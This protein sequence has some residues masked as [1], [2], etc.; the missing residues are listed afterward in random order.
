M[1]R[2]SKGQLLREKKLSEREN[3]AVN[4]MLNDPWFNKLPIPEQIKITGF[5]KSK[6]DRHI[7]VYEVQGYEKGMLDCMVC[8]LQV[9]LE[10]YWKKA[11]KKKLNKF[12]N[13][14]AELMNSSLRQVVTWDEMKQYIMDR[15]GVEIATDWMGKDERPTP[16]EL[17][18]EVKD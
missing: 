5:I 3:K 17:F 8:V 14:V 12:V 1:R 10:D 13:D 18:K 11:S 15:A 6:V 16:K 4:E 2:K 7:G 9:L